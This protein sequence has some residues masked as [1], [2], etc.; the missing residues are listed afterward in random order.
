MT[1]AGSVQL[2]K[3]LET[4][5]YRMCHDELHPLNCAIQTSNILSEISRCKTRQTEHKDS[6][7]ENISPNEVIT[8]SS[9]VKLPSNE[10][11]RILRAFSIQL[12]EYH[13][14]AVQPIHVQGDLNEIR[15]EYAS[16]CMQLKRQ[17]ATAD[18]Q[19]LDCALKALSV[20]DSDEKRGGYARLQ[21]LIDIG[22]SSMEDSII[23]L[24]NKI[25]ES[26]KEFVA[27]RQSEELLESCAKSSYE[28]MRDSYNA[29]LRACRKRS[30]DNDMQWTALEAE[31]REWMLNEMKTTLDK[32]VHN[33]DSTFGFT[34]N[35]REPTAM[36]KSRLTTSRRYQKFSDHY[37][38]TMEQNEKDSLG[39]LKALCRA[40]KNALR[41]K[42][43]HS[44]QMEDWLLGSTSTVE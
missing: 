7:V 28:R 30:H 3:F 12:D 6:N 41:Y 29:L 14:V 1:D 24:S 20:L 10:I 39:Y 25:S 35:E 11:D 9:Q 2:Q 16:A 5:F 43:Q 8:Q 21:S 34:A 18:E 26:R 13:R 22:I 15:S 42:M 23:S 19:R 38:S 44:A 4:Y 36:E 27:I 32:Y 33:T 37:L 17:I 40:R 31:C